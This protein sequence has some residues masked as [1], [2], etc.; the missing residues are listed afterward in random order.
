MNEDNNND[1]R[2]DNNDKSNNN[3]DSNTN[4]DNKKD[5]NDENNNS[6]NN[7][8]ENNQNVINNNTDFLKELRKNLCFQFHGLGNMLG[9]K[10]NRCHHLT[11]DH[12]E[13]V[14]G[15]YKCSKCPYDDNICRVN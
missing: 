9:L 15:E 12:R 5:D 8:I 6:Q 1:E 3:S 7:N 11:I 4:E 14:L 13:I 2:N 10:C